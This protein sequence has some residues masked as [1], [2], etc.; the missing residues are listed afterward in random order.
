MA[1]PITSNYPD[2]GL[3]IPFWKYTNNE[4]ILNRLAIKPLHRSPLSM[5]AVKSQM[6][7]PLR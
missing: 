1:K 6:M 7:M 4:D 2:E 5:E 3:V